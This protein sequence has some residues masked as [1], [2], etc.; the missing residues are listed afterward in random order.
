[1]DDGAGAGGLLEKY[2]EV[3]GQPARP[4]DAA[5]VLLMTAADDAVID[6]E[7][8]GS[9]GADQK[10]HSAS[11]FRIQ[12]ADADGQDLHLAAINEEWRCHLLQMASMAIF[13]PTTLG[14]A[15]LSLEVRPQSQRKA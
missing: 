10:L 14:E 11:E 9:A 12:S 4:L 5:S 13:L 2:R 1:M 7:Q 8:T 6:T 15:A 3:D